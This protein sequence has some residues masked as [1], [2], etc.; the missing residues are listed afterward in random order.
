MDQQSNL[1][2]FV[3]LKRKKDSKFINEIK[4]RDQNR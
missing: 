3:T 1:N 2:L 4:L